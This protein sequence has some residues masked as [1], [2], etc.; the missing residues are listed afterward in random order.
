M[1][2]SDRA[3]VRGEVV[4]LATTA[5]FAACL[6]L[7]A[8][9]AAKLYDIA[10]AGFVVAVPVG[11]TI[12]ALTLVAVSL[13]NECRGWRTAMLLV[14][15]GLLLRGGALAFLAFAVAVEPTSGWPGQE[16]YAQVLQAA[17]HVL[18][19]GIAA[20]VASHLLNVWL[21]DRLRRAGTGLWLRAI[22]AGGA[23]CVLDTVI[24]VLLAF[25]HS[26]DSTVLW[27]IVAGQIVVKLGVV[28]LATPLL[29]LGRG[30]AR[31][32]RADPD[33]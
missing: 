32:Q 20:Y 30:L 15:L 16:A 27:A 6:V 22:L 9:T 11:T 2:G 28:V 5:L 12:Y 23:A 10:L 31:E 19:A 1:N 24:F 33:P 29:Y 8:A 13:I 18:R 26:Q 25:G 17:D 4:V 14:V 3:P 7:S 21:F